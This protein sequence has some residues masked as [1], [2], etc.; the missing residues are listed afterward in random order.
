MLVE[1][2]LPTLEGG[3]SANVLRERTRKRE[4]IIKNLKRLSH[5]F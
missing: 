5:Q 3:K 4:R 1:N 2:T